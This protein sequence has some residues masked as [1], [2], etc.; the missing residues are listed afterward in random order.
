MD[1]TGDSGDNSESVTES[2]ETTESTDQA[3][4]VVTAA[5][6][7][8]TAE[9]TTQ[10]DAAAAEPAASPAAAQLPYGAPGAAV[11][12][13]P[14][15][16]TV[17]TRATALVR[18][19]AVERFLAAAVGAVVVYAAAWLLALVF[20]L[21]AFVAAVDAD[22]DWGLA[23]AAPAQIV[24]LAV[25][26]TLTVG[27]TV[28]GIS[29]A[30]SVLWLPLLVTAFLLV[31]AALV[32]RRDERI[33]PSATRGIRWLLSALTGVV[34]ALLV[35]V[36]AA[37]TP[38]AYAVG[39]ATDTGFGLFSGSGSASSASFT[40][41]V[42][43]VVIGTLASYLARARVARR[44]A[45]IAPPAVPRA[46]STVVAAVRSTLPVLGLHFGVLAGLLTVA[47][48]ISAVVNS[49]FDTLLTA[50]FWLPTLVVD[51]LGLVNLAPVTL[52]GSLGTLAGLTGS[53]TSF[54][55]PSM[56]PAWATVLV[57]IVNLAL[58]V[59]TGI[60]LSLRRAQLRLSPAV[61]WLTTILSF[62]LAGVAVSLLGGIAAWT[63]VDT[64][65]VGESLDGLLGGVGSLVE[66][67]AAASGTLGLAAW[68]FIVF[69]ALGAIVEVISVW[70]A[71][72]LV[73][74]VPA[75]GLA[76]AAR[77]TALVGVPFAVPGT[78]VSGDTVPATDEPAGASAEGVSTPEAVGPLAPMSPEK[79][80]R[81]RIVLVAVGG[82]AVLVLG[83]SVAITIVN[84]VAFS[85]R[86]QVEIY[87]DAMVAGDASTALEI[88]NADVSKAERTLLTD[89]MLTATDGGI[90]GYTIT[91]VSAGSNS[92]LVT[93][94]VEQAGETEEMTY[95]LLKSG[96]TALVFDQ[97]VLDPVHLASLN[98]FFDSGIS[99]LDVNGVTVELTGSDQESGT[100]HLPAFPGEYVV[101]SA[102]DDAW[103]AAEPQTVVLGVSTRVSEDA[104]QLSLEPTDKFVESVD[105]QVSDF[106]AECAAEKSL[107]AD[108]CPIYAY[109]YGTITDV[110]WT[111]DEPAV[112]ELD[113]S[114]AGEWYVTTEDRGSATVTY[115]NT[116]YRGAAQQ[117]T[118]TVAFS[119]NGTVALVD[120][121]PVFTNGY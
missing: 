41:F 40:A 108:D 26:G 118:K 92:A 80:R 106:L 8:G 19:I 110:V 71:P 83:V 98:V 66:G 88:G 116:D 94:D 105:D 119:I 109:D 5:Q 61:S 33:A 12:A 25:A 112:T 49:G 31:A 84:Q 68:T 62:A 96:T 115:T 79:K 30:V 70:V 38:L 1:G 13:Q 43:A 46:A 48:L 73:Q 7:E 53:A 120:G 24:G 90:T 39:D 59:V 91:D 47:L 55:M 52:N 87:L 32:A 81:V 10:E 14:A 65:G 111:I 22:L 54:W 45:G 23:F 29:A 100:L 3:D 34:L 64:S 97:W 76:R 6:P 2:T 95:T 121:K 72:A 44:V 11:S 58:I 35:I 63:S 77:L 101:G 103:V 85:P 113:T 107:T 78:I 28:M 16:P 114:Y 75:A 82:A 56:I 18:G 9:P 93:A 27:A 102:G 99:E 117:E 86:H 4:G 67:A 37:V 57:L 60:V 74:L 69:A 42:G 36:I 20:T 50:F 15:G 17:V 51:S 21:L 104:A 89:A